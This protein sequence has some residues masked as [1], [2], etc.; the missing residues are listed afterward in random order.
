[1]DLM[2]ILDGMSSCSTYICKDFSN[3]VAQMLQNLSCN[4]YGKYICP[5]VKCNDNLN[6]YLNE[7]YGK[8]FGKPSITM[9]SKIAANNVSADFIMNLQQFSSGL[10]VM[11]NGKIDE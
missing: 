1:M 7:L 6:T 2:N 5:L 3:M 10:S 4:K 9:N 8:L 11:T